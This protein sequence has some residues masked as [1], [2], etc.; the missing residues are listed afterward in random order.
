M[1]KGMIILVLISLFI[2]LACSKKSTEVQ[3]NE[4]ELQSKV[5][6]RI[7]SLWTNYIVQNSLSY[8]GIA[9][10][11]QNATKS[12]FAKANMPENVNKNAYFRGASNTKTFTAFAI[13]KLESQGKL[14]IEDR[15]TDLIP[16]TNLTYLPED[17][18]YNIPFKQQITIR[19]LLEHRAGVFDLTNFAIPDTVNANYAG[20][21]WLAYM[22]QINPYYP[23]T[24]DGIIGIISQHQLY[25]HLP[26][27]DYSYTN[28]GYMLLAKIIE[29]VSNQ[30]FEE[31]L[32]ENVLNTNQLTQIQ[33]PTSTASMLPDPYISGKVWSGNLLYD[34][35][36]FNM[37]SAKGSGNVVCTLADLN[38]WVR[39][40]QKGQAGLDISD[41]ETMRHSSNP[42]QEY[43]GLGTEYIPGI[44][45]G[46]T[47]AIAGYLSFMFYDP[48]TDFSIVLVANIWNLNTENSLNEQAQC[49]AE[50][51]VQAKEICVPGEKIGMKQIELLRKKILSECRKSQI[52]MY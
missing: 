31:Y 28:T 34:Y 48:L 4:D 15:L 27:Q 42:D 44:G 30:S 37:S 38:R 3:N 43:Y 13:M 10:M 11:A 6:N 39:S 33:F 26:D 35:R 52:M 36:R 17:N 20:Q 1:K 40:W 22:S 49:M 50:I 8:G 41:V 23:F 32:S 14:N 46:H 24:I 5:Q 29:R 51:I 18:N 7:N 9:L 16:N 2:L 12:V 45:Y 25:H 19:Q 21:N 47:G